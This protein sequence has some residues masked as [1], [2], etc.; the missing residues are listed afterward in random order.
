MIVAAHVLSPTSE[1][2][3]ARDAGAPGTSGTEWAVTTLGVVPL[4]ASKGP[5]C[6][7]PFESYVDVVEV[8]ICRPLE[9]QGGME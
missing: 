6:Y 4:G 3:W 7:P 8:D 9:M 1:V 2:S 5:C